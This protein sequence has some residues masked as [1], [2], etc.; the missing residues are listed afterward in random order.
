MY[1]L[2]Q[3][4][5]LVAKSGTVED[6]DNFDSSKTFRENGVDSLEVMGL[7]LAVEEGLGVKFSEDEANSIN[8][9]DEMLSLLNSKMG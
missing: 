7:F 1:K 5:D 4:L 6:M 3:I 2:N 8:T 9:I